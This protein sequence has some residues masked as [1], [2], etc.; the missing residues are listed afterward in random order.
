MIANIRAA[1]DYTGFL[2]VAE[3]VVSKRRDV[4]FVSLGYGKLNNDLL[5]NVSPETKSRLFFLGKI[6][7]PEDYVKS[8]DIGLLLNDTRHG[9]EGIS[10]S[11]ME[12]MAT[13]LP[14][15]ATNAGGTPELVEEGFSGFLV[16]A[17]DYE[18]VAQKI[19]YL[20]DN[21]KKRVE[22]GHRGREIIFEKFSLFRMGKEYI[23]LYSEL[24]NDNQILIE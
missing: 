3:M 21:E 9:K 12:Y 20:I 5:L 15:I 19:L 6:D 22:M 16:P 8:F 4:A 7:N 24:V 2:K 18:F 14:V 11:I 10:N 13:G 1:K 23:K 17:F